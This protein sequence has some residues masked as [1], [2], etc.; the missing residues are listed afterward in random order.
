VRETCKYE[1]ER[2]ETTLPYTKNCSMTFYWHYPSSPKFRT[3]KKKRNSEGHNN[4]VRVSASQH[5]F[6][7]PFCAEGENAASKASSLL[8]A[9]PHVVEIRQGREMKLT[10]TPACRN[11]QSPSMAS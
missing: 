2:V 6:A 8:R 5:Y 4:R 1:G 9:T 10:S 11:A 7:L 3:E